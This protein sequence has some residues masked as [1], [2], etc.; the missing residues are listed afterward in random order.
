[1]DFLPGRPYPSRMSE[2][3][4][5]HDPV[6]NNFVDRDNYGVHFY[7][8]QH[9]QSCTFLLTHG[10]S[11]TTLQDAERVFYRTLTTK[12]SAQ[13][14]FVDMRLGAVQ[15]A[16]ELFG[17][18]SAQADATAAAFDAVE[19]FEAPTNPIPTP[20]P[21]IPGND[22]T[23]FVYWDGVAGAYYLGRLDPEL[24]ALGIQFSANPVAP[25]AVRFWRRFLLDIRR[26]AE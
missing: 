20:V 1:M 14:D 5:P 3:I 15:S 21:A 23:L 19:I 4:Q 7:E 2:F 8:Q 10:P 25:P 11:A 9:H 13:S 24:D 17:N 18:G 26:R 16:R 12:L 22:A 6:L